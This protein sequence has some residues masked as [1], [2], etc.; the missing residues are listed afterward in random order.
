MIRP[1]ADSGSYYYNYKSTHSIVLLAVVDASY[2]FIYVDI[3]TN[4]RISDG[5][6]WDSS[7]FKSAIENSALN[8]PPEECLPGTDVSVPYVFLGDD[9]FPLKTYFMKPYPFRNQSDQERTFSYRL[10]R[11]RRTVENAFGIL[12][13]R[14]RVF[15]S[16]INLHPSKVEKIVLASTALHNFLLAENAPGY[17][18][19]SPPDAD[20]D[21]PQLMPLEI[22]QSGRPCDAAK[23]VRQKFTWYFNNRGAVPWQADVMH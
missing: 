12:A 23:V 16:P 19:Y 17:S 1:P 5:G 13:N 22:T 8:I 3:G 2:K 15:L 7:K 11:A 9:A 4:G 6:V 18:E 10:S 14:F 20:T 21:H